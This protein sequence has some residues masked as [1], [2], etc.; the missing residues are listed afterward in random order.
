MLFYI[1]KSKGK[2]AHYKCVSVSA[3]V[4][5]QPSIGFSRKGVLQKRSK[6]T[7]DHP[8]RS[9]ISIKLHSK[10]SSINLHFFECRLVQLTLR[11]NS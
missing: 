7:G 3:D 4:Q 10:N 1:N 2:Y 6:F 9:V 5:K 8:C 11:L